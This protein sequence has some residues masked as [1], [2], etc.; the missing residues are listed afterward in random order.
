MTRL[1]R[2]AES[3][4]DIAIQEAR[5]EATTSETKVGRAGQ[6]SA[7]KTRSGTSQ[8]AQKSKEASL[9]SARCV[10]VYTG[11]GKRQKKGS[12]DMQAEMIVKKVSFPAVTGYSK[13]A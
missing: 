2:V 11:S 5:Q 8:A 13:A 6:A 4:S 7:S 12:F 3:Q 9:E 1:I 10:E